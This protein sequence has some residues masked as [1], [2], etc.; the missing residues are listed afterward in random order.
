[1]TGGREDG[2]TAIDTAFDFRTDAG[3]KDPDSHSPTL[4]RYHKLLWSK[5]LPSGAQFD[6]DEY[7]PGTY[8]H[9]RSDLGEF[10]LSSDSVIATFTHWVRLK[11]ITKQLTA[12]ENEAF[13][14]IG[15]TIGGMMIF[16]ANKVDGGM[17]INGAR[18]FNQSIADRMDLTL[19]CIRRHYAGENSP[20]SATLER[21]ADFFALFESFPGYVDFFLLD[22]LVVENG[23]AVKF[24]MPFE[25]FA[26][27][28]VPQDI[29]TYE[30]Y[31]RRS[32]DFIVARNRRI[33]DWWRAKNASDQSS[34]S[35]GEMTR[36]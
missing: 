15:Y 1:M 18:G 3:G 35:E 12:A 36:Q 27:P 16:P 31:R 2:C 9:H 28:S 4:R 29:D 23:D 7:A 11:H 6:L 25:N 26:P 8:L 17:T 34:M 30:E 19:E 10:Y 22:D 21:Y 32:I 13:R 5:L 24:F 14:T 20:L 33:A